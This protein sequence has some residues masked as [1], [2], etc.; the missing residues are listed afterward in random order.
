MRRCPG[1]APTFG[2][3]AHR[4]PS[5]PGRARRAAVQRH[6]PRGPAA[7]VDGDPR[8]RAPGRRRDRLLRPGGL[9]G[10]R[11]DDRQR[12]GI[13]RAG[14]LP[15]PAGPAAGATA[16]DRGLGRGGGLPGGV[17]DADWPRWT[18]YRL[19]G[20]DGPV[21]ALHRHLRPGPM[22]A[23]GLRTTPAADGVRPRV[24]GRRGGV[25]RRSDRDHRARDGLGPRGRARRDGRRRRRRHA[26]P[27]GAALHRARRRTPGPPRSRTARRMPWRTVLP[28]V[29]VALALGC[30][31]GSAEVATVA[32]AEEHDAPGATGVLL[33]LWA[34]GSLLAGVLAGA[35]H[36]QA[37]PGVPG[38]GRHLRARVRHGPARPDRPGVADGRWPCSSPASPSPPA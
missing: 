30:L 18:A 21:P 32:F 34:L 4:L 2:P 7:V 36:D 10:R 31:F 35:V 14:P 29:V 12:G 1:R 8:H 6:R 38:E 37:V 5:D 26:R 9:P 16:A 33:A 17:G 28:L 3:D 20:G 27:G 25:H 24:G 22:G 11:D 19:R 15:R 13:D 23:R